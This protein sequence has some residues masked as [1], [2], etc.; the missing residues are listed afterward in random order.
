MNEFASQGAHLPP[1]SPQDAAFIL[2]SKIK[3][4]KKKL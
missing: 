2:V 3:P 1:N 4:K